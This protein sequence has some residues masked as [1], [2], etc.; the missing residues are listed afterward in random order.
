MD[1]IDSSN[2]I[3]WEGRPKRQRRAPATYW[4]EYV[5]T[6]EWYHKELL[7]DV[8]PEEIEAACFDSDIDDDA[9]SGSLPD[10]EAEDVAYSEASESD[11]SE[12][13]SVSSAVSEESA[14][15]LVITFDT[16]DEDDDSVLESSNEGEPG[17]E[18]SDEESEGGAVPQ[19]GADLI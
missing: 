4:E 11:A 5:E 12:T 10:S 7:G 19:T 18:G 9:A 3:S 8:P 6:D 16:E 17:G 2:V 1:W 15:E 14:P 13:E